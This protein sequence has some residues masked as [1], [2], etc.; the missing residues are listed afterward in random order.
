MKVQKTGKVKADRPET[1]EEARRWERY[2]NKYIENG[3]CHTDA[4]QAAW[5]HQIG[6]ALSNK[7][8]SACVLLMADM[9]VISRGSDGVWR[10]WTPDILND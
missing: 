6:F 1:I 4:C 10:R 8:C 7:P 3:F 2:K 5:G 9:P